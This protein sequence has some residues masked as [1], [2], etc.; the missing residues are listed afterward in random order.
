MPCPYEE[1]T[2]K[3]KGILIIFT[4]TLAALIL[5]GV[6]WHYKAGG[7]DQSTEGMRGMAGMSM[8]TEGMSEET[9][10]EGAFVQTAVM[11][12]PTQQQ[13]IGV[14]TAIVQKQ[15]LTSEIRAV[16]TVDYDERRIRQINLRVSG[17]IT[18]MFAD[19]TGKSVR[20]GDPLFSLY[21]PDLVATAQEYLLAQETLQQIKESPFGHLRAGTVAQV[22]SARSR[23]LLLNLTE[24]QIGALEQSGRSQTEIVIH[25]PSDGIIT[26]KTAIEGMYVTPEMNLYEIADLSV[27]WIYADLYEYELALVEVGQ[28][29]VVTLTAYHGETFRGKVVYIYPYLNTETRTIKIRMEFANADGKLKPNMYGEV[30]IATHGRQALAVPEEAV[31]DSGTRTLIFMDQGEGMYVPR[32]VTLGNPVGRYY[33]VIEGVEAGERIVTSA[34]FL[35]DSESKLM[36]AT[37][38]MGMLGMGGIKMEQAQ[39]GEMD[40]GGM[41]MGDMKTM[42]MDGMKDM[43]MDPPASAREQT[44]SG[45]TLTLST[46]PDPPKKGKNRIRLTA[47]AKGS[48]VIGA[49]VTLAYTMAMPGMDVET[50]AARDVQEGVYEADIDLPM[51]GAWDI[52]AVLVRGSGKPVKAKFI[53]TVEQ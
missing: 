46:D 31:L 48:P 24:A 40:M 25:A 39:M 20:K 36:A 22:A 53:V 38:M 43:K 34:T 17:W 42:K 12:S 32:A 5:I 44:V 52:E 26:K 49:D 37:N 15:M 50:V 16:G 41:Q 14:K 11:I 47:R 23:L 4:S 13:Q 7:A 51:R 27:V 28:E 45:L 35:I 6:G 21:S 10:P 8:A 29:A 33:P 3:S 9:A 18:K 19:Y 30:K 2:M 1:E